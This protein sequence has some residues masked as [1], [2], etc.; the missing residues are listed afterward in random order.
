MNKRNMLIKLVADSL[1]V[2]PSETIKVGDSGIDILEGKN[3]EAGIYIYTIKARV[4]PYKTTKL[5]G[6]VTLER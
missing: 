6:C 4:S 3:A 2:K 1:K 5:S